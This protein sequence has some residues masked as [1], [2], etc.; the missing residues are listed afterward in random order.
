MKEQEKMDSWL[1]SGLE[2]YQPQSNQS[3]KERFLMDAAAISEKGN[4][5]S[6]WLI[7][8]LLA[9]ATFTATMFIIWPTDEQATQIIK[10]TYKQIITTINTPTTITTRAT[11]HTMPWCEHRARRLTSLVTSGSDTGPSSVVNASMM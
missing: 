9:I 2:N 8:A 11:S 5:K 10:N 4:K 3:A 6:Y 7:P 1:R